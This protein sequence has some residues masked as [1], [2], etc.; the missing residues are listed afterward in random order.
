MEEKKKILRT[1]ITDKQKKKIVADY[2]QLRNYSEVARLNNVNDTTV[3]RIVVKEYPEFA[4]EAEEKKLENTISTLEYM[5]TQ[6]ET[7]K[8]ILDKLLRAIEI[9]TEDI[10]MLTNIKD[11]AT[12]YGIILDKELKVLELRK[13]AVTGEEITKV[14]EL[15]SKIEKEAQK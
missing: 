3:K 14:E 9:K 12:A 15:L 2:V 6:H 11:L 13:N 7:K 5:D 10:N 4:N 8:R 1:R